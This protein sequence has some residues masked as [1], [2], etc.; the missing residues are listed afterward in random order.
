M[1]GIVY[2]RHSG[3]PLCISIYRIYSNCHVY[4]FGWKNKPFNFNL[5]P[6][7][8]ISGRFSKSNKIFSKYNFSFYCIENMPSVPVGIN[9]QFIPFVHNAGTTIYNMREYVQT[10]CLLVVT[11]SLK[12]L[13]GGELF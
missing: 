1:Q 11:V 12:V 6:L 5:M 3:V 2:T 7:C 13:H 9:Y 10:Y 8:F 4:C